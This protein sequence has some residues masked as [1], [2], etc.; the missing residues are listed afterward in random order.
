MKYMQSTGL[1]DR[2]GV[3]IYTDD[4]YI[5]D[6]NDRVLDTMDEDQLGTFIDFLASGNHT[7]AKVREELETLFAP[8]PIWSDKL[9]EEDNRTWVLCFLSHSSPEE[10]DHTGWVCNSYSDGYKEHRQTFL[11]SYATPIDLNLRYYRELR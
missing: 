5:A 3:D 11:W 1:K 9:D 7:D 2:N 10:T 4:I 8:L 6:I